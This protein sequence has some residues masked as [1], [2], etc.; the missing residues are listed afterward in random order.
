MKQAARHCLL[1][2]PL[3]PVIPAQAGIF[4]VP[5]IGLNFFT[6]KP[7]SSRSKHEECFLKNFVPF[8]VN[9]VASW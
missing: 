1:P 4:P 8:F 9:F 5:V 6:T 3:L 2:P 7:R